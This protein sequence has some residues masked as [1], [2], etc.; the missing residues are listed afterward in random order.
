MRIL[1]VKPGVDEITMAI[2]SGARKA[3]N[4]ETVSKEVYKIAQS[5]DPSKDLV[6]VVQE[7]KRI[8]KECKIDEVHVVKATKPPKGSLSPERVKN[9]AAIQFAST[10][11]GI[12]VKLIAPQTIRAAE[13]KE[14]ETVDSIFEH[15]FK[16]KDKR[17]V[18][19]L[20]LIGLS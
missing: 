18:A 5:S 19:F 17:E 15:K 10:E 3:P 9:E 8:I 20:G 6:E 4:L 16:S 2:V 11:Q 7:F 1:A 13:K 12:P 14:E